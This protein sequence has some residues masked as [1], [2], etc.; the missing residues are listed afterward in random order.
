MRKG[1]LYILIFALMVSVLQTLKYRIYVFK[2]FS[3]RSLVFI[4]LQISFIFLIIFL[5]GIVFVR[6]YYKQKDK[7][8]KF[9]F[10]SPPVATVRINTLNV[11][12]LFDGKTAINFKKSIQDIKWYFFVLF[13]YFPNP[14]NISTTPSLCKMR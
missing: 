3:D 9:W 7:M 2:D 5:P 6:W 11:N 13:S 10:L 4:F 8:N 1:Y 14:S 12:R